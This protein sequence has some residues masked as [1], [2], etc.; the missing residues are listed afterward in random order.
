[1]AVRADLVAAAERL[2]MSGVVE[3]M[4]FEFTAKQ[5]ALLR[6]APTKEVAVSKSTSSSSTTTTTTTTHSMFYKGHLYNIR[7]SQKGHMA[8]G[9]KTEHESALVIRD[10]Y[11][12]YFAVSLVNHTVCTTGSTGTNAV[13]AAGTATTAARVSVPLSVKLSSD[14]PV[15]SSSSETFQKTSAAAVRIYSLQLEIR[16]KSPLIKAVTDPAI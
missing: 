2:Q 14:G 3:G 5:L 12:G 1:M 4:R 8:L 7:D 9:P 10:L 11:S 15:S 13:P 16:I 6:K